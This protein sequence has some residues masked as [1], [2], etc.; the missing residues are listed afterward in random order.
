MR[1]YLVVARTLGMIPVIIRSDRGVE[2]P[3]MADAHHELRKAAAPEANLQIGDVYAF[4]KSIYNIRIEGWWAQLSG[5][6]IHRWRVG[7]CFLHY[8]LYA[9]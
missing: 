5:C 1:Q 2:T 6:N 4:G 9:N 8:N 3:M 7:L